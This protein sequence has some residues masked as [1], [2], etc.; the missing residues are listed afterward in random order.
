MLGGNEILH[1]VSLDVA[2]GEFITLL[3]P[4]GSGK[5]TTLNVIAGLETGQRRP[6]A[7]RRQSRSRSGPRTSATS[8]WCSSPTR[9][10]RT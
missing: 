7:L 5:T 2:A 9:C 1:G 10:S 4:S 6:R 8:G 3:G